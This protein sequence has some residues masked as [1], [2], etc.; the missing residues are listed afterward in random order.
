MPGLGGVG[1]GWEEGDEGGGER[2]GIELPHLL[3]V[4]ITPPGNTITL[5]NE[6]MLN[7]PP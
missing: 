6:I 3:P 1:F 2:E 7:R 5:I 4:L